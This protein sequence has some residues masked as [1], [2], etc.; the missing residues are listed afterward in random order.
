MKKIIVI[1]ATIMLSGIML[2]AQSTKSKVEVL[3]FKANLACCKARACYVLEVDIQNIVGKDTSIVFREIK[4]ADEANK[5]LVE[6]YKA[7][8]QTVIIIKKKKKKEYSTDISDIVQAY[9]QNQN[10]ET[11]EKELMNKIN[12]IKKK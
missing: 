9:V 5:A 2:S 1:V 8:S 6:K 10:K 3:Y 4:L 7:K 12:E 11:L